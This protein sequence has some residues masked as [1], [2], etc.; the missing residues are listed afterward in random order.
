MK[1]FL[2]TDNEVFGIVAPKVKVIDGSIT[3]KGTADIAART[4]PKVHD[5]DC[6]TSLDTDTGE[7]WGVCANGSPSGAFVE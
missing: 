2:A 5:V 4:M 6:N 3:E 1:K 7:T